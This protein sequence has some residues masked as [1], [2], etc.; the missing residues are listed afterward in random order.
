MA[1]IR[2][3]GVLHLAVT[4]DLVPHRD[5]PRCLIPLKG[6]MPT[7]S[8]SHR[9]PAPSS[10][11]WRKCLLSGWVKATDHRG[12][13]EQGAGPTYLTQRPVPRPSGSLPV[14]AK[15]SGQHQAECWVAMWLETG[16]HHPHA[17]AIPATAWSGT[18][19]TGR[20]WAESWRGGSAGRTRRL[21]SSGCSLHG[22]LN[23]ALCGLHHPGPLQ[24]L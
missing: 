24:V 22:T 23:E 1:G 17:A 12:P 2:V 15:G 19:E 10:V 21:E 13:G 5:A 20:G 14:T 6:C 18:G 11:L 16:C 8:P 4:L 3:Y 9:C 7:P